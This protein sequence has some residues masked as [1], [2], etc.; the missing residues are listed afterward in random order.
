MAPMPAVAAVPLATWLRLGRVSNLPTIWTNVMAATA[1]AGGDPLDWHTASVLLA[2]TMF[3]I[4]GMYLNDAFDREID[5]RERPT[6]PIPRG[7]IAPRPVFAV[8]FGLLV[9]GMALMTTFGPAAFVAGVGLSA[10]IIS[11]DFYHKQNPFS[12]VLMGLCRLLVYVGAALASIGAVPGAIWS[13]GIAM[14]AHVIGLTYAA[15]Q[16][17]LDRIDRLWPLVFLLIPL[18]LAMAALAN[19]P[20]TLVFWL[21]LA[22]ADW[23]ALDKLRRRSTPEAVPSGISM[24]IA[25]ISLVDGVFAVPYSLPV[26][27]LAVGAFA[28]TYFAQR[29]VRGT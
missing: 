28:A 6:R 9:A 7:E 18:V 4:G 12:P 26:A 3:Y 10:A 11:Y 22:A 23:R 17:G 8:G 19:A 27:I 25:A 29:L 24:M 21:L 14:A 5:A 2:M 1:I 20:W 15:K 13:A 16:E